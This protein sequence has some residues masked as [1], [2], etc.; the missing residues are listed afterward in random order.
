MYAIVKWEKG[1]QEG[2]L[3]IDEVRGKGDA[4]QIARRKLR[5]QGIARVK[6]LEVVVVGKRSP[7]EVSE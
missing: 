2:V 3:E 6:I 4:E 5:E 7:I 1:N